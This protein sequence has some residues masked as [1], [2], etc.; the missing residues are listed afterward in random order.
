MTEIETGLY[1]EVVVNFNASMITYGTSTPPPITVRDAR[2]NY[3][4]GD[5]FLHVCGAREEYSFQVTDVKSIHY[6]HYKS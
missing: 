6:K 1:E 5:R 2:V 3:T 4:K